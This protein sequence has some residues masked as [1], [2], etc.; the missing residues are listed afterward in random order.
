MCQFTCLYLSDDLA[1]FRVDLGDA[2]SLRQE[3][4]NFVELEEE[5]AEDGEKVQWR[6][7]Y[8]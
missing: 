8:V 3:G 4:E 5:D 1:I 7:L 6:C 2:A